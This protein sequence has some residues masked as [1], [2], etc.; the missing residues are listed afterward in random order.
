MTI[1]RFHNLFFSICFI[2]YYEK[3]YIEMIYMIH[4]LIFE[5]KYFPYATG[6]L[7]E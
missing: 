6:T 1:D 2:L 5:A 3:K 4:G 7:T